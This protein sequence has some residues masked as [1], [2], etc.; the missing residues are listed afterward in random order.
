[1]DLGSSVFSRGI[2][3]IGDRSSGTANSVEGRRDR[4]APDGEQMFSQR[5]FRV[6]GVGGAL[7]PECLPGAGLVRTCPGEHFLDDVSGLFPH[8]RGVSPRGHSCC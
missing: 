3:V 4:Y 7:F 1:M 5:R 8:A 2:V 6:P